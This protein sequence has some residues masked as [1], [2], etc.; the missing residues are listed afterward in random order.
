MSTPR[1]AES[2]PTVTAPVVIPEA[3]GA[4]SRGR[5]L[6]GVIAGGVLLA[7]DLALLILAAVVL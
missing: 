6:A 3:R 2:L 5:F 4:L 1:Q 7:V